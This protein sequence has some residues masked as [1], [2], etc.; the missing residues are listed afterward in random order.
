MNRMLVKVKLGRY[1]NRLESTGN[2]RRKMPSQACRPH[3]LK[4]PRPPCP[5]RY[6]RHQAWPAMC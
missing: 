2:L 4:V 1:P 6:S 3:L 5:R